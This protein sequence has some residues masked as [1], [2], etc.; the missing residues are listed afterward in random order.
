MECHLLGG[1]GLNFGCVPSKAI[2]RST[3]VAADIREPGGL[4]FKV[5]GGTRIDFPA[6]MVRNI[7]LG[8]LASVIHPYPTKAEAIRQMGDLYNRTRL[9]PGLKHL[10]ARFLAWRR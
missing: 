2:I 9:T 1:D 5:P 6:V 4:L 3:Q 10:F 7:S 8:T